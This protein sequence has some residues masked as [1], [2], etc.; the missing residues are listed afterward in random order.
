MRGLSA[1]NRRATDDPAGTRAP[2][3]NHAGQ[4]RHADPRPQPGPP[5]RPHAPA[6]P[7]AAGAGGE[8]LPCRVRLADGRVFRGALPR[9]APPR[10]PARDA[11]RRHR[12][13]RRAH[14]RHAPRRRAARASTAAAGPSTTCPAAPAAT[15]AGCARCSRTPSGSSPAPTRTH[16]CRRTARARRCSSASRR[17]RRAARRQGRR[18]RTRAGCG[19][20]STGPSGSTRC[21][22]FLA[23]RPCHLLI[24]SGGSGGV[25]AYWQLAEPLPA[26]R[27]DSRS[28]EQVVEPI[29]RAHLRIIH[30]LGVDA[31][32]QAERRRPALRGAL[33][34]DAPGRHDQLQDRRGTRGSSRPTSRSRRTRSTSSSAT[35]PTPRRRRPPRARA[36]TASTTTTRTSGSRRPSTSSGSPASRVPRGGLVCCPV[37]GHDD[38]HPSCSVGADARAG[39]VLPCSARCGARGAIYDLASVLHGGPWGRELRGEAFERARARVV[40]VFGERQ[41][42]A[43][44]APAP[45]RSQSPRR[46]RPGLYVVCGPRRG[47]RDARRP[48]GRRLRQPAADA[49]SRRSRS[50][51][52]CSAAPPTDRTAPAAGHARSPAAGAPSRSRPR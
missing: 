49:P 46:S 8:P 44:H 18:R 31:D 39:L 4:A 42:S 41:V 38:P 9:R 36:A 37:P 3:P 22:R 50:S 30:A 35:C 5:A 2:A 17:A 13:A 23:E 43:A 32:G 19:S 21:G 25:H 26:T 33:A 12:R 27:P 24:E 6:V 20:T 10:A 51:R 1:C 15:R 7:T 52:C 16:V 11:A 34:R 40:A 48:R 14:A 47:Q 45:R 28:G 29:E